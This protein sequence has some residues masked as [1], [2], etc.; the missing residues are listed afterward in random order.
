MKK[1]FIIASIILVAIASL[2]LVG[3]KIIESELNNRLKTISSYGVY[4]KKEIADTKYLQTK[5]YYE[6]VVTD[7]D[8]LLKYLSKFSNSQIPPY[9]SKFLDGTT[10]AV[11]LK[12]NNIP[13]NDMVYISFRPIALSK[14][15]IN[16][17]KKEDPG[18]AAYLESFLKNGGLEYHIDYNVLKQEFRGYIKD[19]DESYTFASGQKL[20]AKL[21]GAVF[22]G[23]GL[24]VAPE[25]IDSNIDKIY[26]D[27]TNKTNN[28]ILD[29]QNIYLTSIFESRT[30]YKTYIKA[31]SLNININDDKTG[32]TILDI[33]KPKMNFASSTKGLKA[34]FTSKSSFEEL[35]LKT[36]LQE[37][38]MLKFNY[39]VSLKDIDKDSFE[40]LSKLLDSAKYGVDNQSTLKIEK[41]LQQLL[42]RGFDLKVSDFSIKN[43]KL[44]K[45]RNLEGASLK[46]G[47]KLASD[48]NINFSKPIE[49]LDKIKLDLLLNIS[50]PM[51]VAVTQSNPIVA[52]SQGYAKEKG[53]SLVYNIKIQNGSVSVNDKRVR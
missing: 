29:I 20:D 32:K 46:L 2:P 26:L 35:N 34:E 21:K 44:N 19:I 23:K 33:K 50:K 10:L 14:K 4:T 43:I 36:K 28:I 30:T 24:L 49:L 25:F 9:I 40:E 15:T 31:N 7:A 8:K 48:S 51:F 3:N 41:S 47:V 17:I 16:E 52:L 45:K 6:F 12:Y 42:M 27:V 53:N 11:E 5:K 13:I 1:L 38:D 39:E 37:V 18:F 22:N